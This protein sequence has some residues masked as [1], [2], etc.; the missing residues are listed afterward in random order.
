M[1]KGSASQK[2]LRILV[3]DDDPDGR[4]IAAELLR[5]L[6]AWTIAANS[7]REALTLLTAMPDIT[8]LFADVVMPGMDG[9][10]LAQQATQQM[11]GL[12]VLLATGYPFDMLDRIPADFPHVD[13][14]TKPFHRADLEQW[15]AT[16]R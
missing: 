15:V 5:A 6:G 8:A 7:G 13:F 16:L 9:L 12:R 3:V 1:E 10:T 11:P 4:E 2:Q 14:I